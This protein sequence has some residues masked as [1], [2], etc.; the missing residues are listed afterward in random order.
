MI[1][2]S[3][4][5][6]NFHIEHW[7]ANSIHLMQRWDTIG[8]DIKYNNIIF[9]KYLD[10]L[11]GVY[12]SQIELFILHRRI[13]NLL[14]YSNKIRVFIAF[15]IRHDNELWC[16]AHCEYCSIQCRICNWGIGFSF[17][18][19]WMWRKLTS[20]CSGNCQLAHQLILR[21]VSN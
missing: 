9:Y 17:R 15:S 5:K 20:R 8:F 12:Y 14:V 16:V 6:S 18:F 10:R 3:V 7:A 4:M 2:Q 19:A 11:F 13:T 1:I 21:P